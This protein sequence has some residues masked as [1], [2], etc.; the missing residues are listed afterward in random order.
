MISGGRK[1]KFLITKHVRRI[2]LKEDKFLFGANLLDGVRTYHDGLWT[3]YIAKDV[4][5][6]LGFADYRKT[7]QRLDTDEKR[8]V[9]V[10]TAGGPQKMVAISLSG[11]YSLLFTSQ[12]KFAHEFRRWLSH[13][14]LMR[15]GEISSRDAEK[16]SLSA[17]IKHIE[18]VLQDSGILKP[19][20]NPQY[21][22]ENLKSRYLAA[23]GDPYVRNFYDSVGN[24]TGYIIP[25][26]SAIRTTVKDWILQHIPLE[27]INEFVIGVETKTIVRNHFGNWVSLNGVFANSVEWGKILKEFDGG[28]AYCGDKK[29]PVIAEH[30]IPKTEISKTHPEA[31]DLAGNIVPTCQRC[32]G[33]KYK[34]DWQ[35]WFKKQPFYTNGRYW[36]IKDH[37][38]KY[39]YD[40]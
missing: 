38:E 35:E 9:T 34:S 6:N 1:K 7:V 29:H 15:V 18:K 26:S 8:Y 20:V 25:H 36:R 21:T 27:Q 11:I 5:A 10:E 24:W 23:T 2:V 37:I 33:S 22:F 16:I 13:D 19:F 39:R 32:N 4:C 31:T 17:D 28:C 40:K 12:K 3:W 14:L 30:I